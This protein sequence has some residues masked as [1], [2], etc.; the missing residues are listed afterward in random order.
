MK[1]EEKEFENQETDNLARRQASSEP[2]EREEAVRSGPFATIREALAGGHQD[3]TTG[4]LKRA[5]FLLAVP[6][7]LEMVM[8]SVFAVVDVYFVASLGASAVATVGLTES[9]LTLIYAVAI[10][11]SMGTTAMVARRIGEKKPKEAAD[12]AFQ[13]VVVGILSSI[14]IMLLGLFFARDT[15]G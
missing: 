12:A 5:L 13:A 8:E 1:Y 4:S 6:M 11:L 2:N 9:F 7:V 14:P 15:T 10:G 3:F